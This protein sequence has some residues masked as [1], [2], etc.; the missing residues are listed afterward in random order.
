[1]CVCMCMCV[2]VCLPRGEKKLLSDVHLLPVSNGGPKYPLL[3]PN[4]KPRPKIST[5]E[6]KIYLLVRVGARIHPI[7]VSH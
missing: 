3:Q 1:M 6:E 4:G 7:T 5:N 2:C